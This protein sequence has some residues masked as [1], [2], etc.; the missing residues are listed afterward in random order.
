VLGVN[1]EL[2]IDA[3]KE[4]KIRQQRATDPFSQFVELDKNVGTTGFL[5]QEMERAP[6]RA[7]IP[8]QSSTIIYRKTYLRKRTSGI[9]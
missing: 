6:V 3:S 1:A 8:S 5:F 4:I 2:Q 9:S 7:Q